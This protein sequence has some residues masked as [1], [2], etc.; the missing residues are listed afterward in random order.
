MFLQDTR[1]MRRAEMRF[2]NLEPNMTEQDP[3]VGP[4]IDLDAMIDEQNERCRA[5][6][7]A[8]IRFQVM[9]ASSLLALSVAI[10]GVVTQQPNRLRHTLLLL[11]WVALLISV[12]LG[13]VRAAGEFH[14]H[15]RYRDRLLELRRRNASY[16]EILTAINTYRIGIGTTWCERWMSWAVPISLLVGLAGLI[17]AALS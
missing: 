13:L 10:Q 17:A 2:T 14:D 16:Q 1:L 8:W 9:V 15:R 12:S 3:R 7:Y 11:S 5:P 6:F 4:P